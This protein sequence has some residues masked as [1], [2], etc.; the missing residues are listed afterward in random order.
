MQI[1]DWIIVSLMLA[2]VAGIA[3]YTRRFVKGVADFLAAG[4]VAGRYVVCVA[5]GEAGLGLISIVTVWEM[6]Y[7]SGFAVGWWNS[8][9]VPIYLLLTL[10]GF[11]IY[12]FRETRSMTLGQL[13]EI[14]YSK[15]FRIFAGIPSAISGIVNYGL[16][17][18]V[19]ARFLVYFCGLPPQL[20]A[21]GMQVPT[22]A[23]LMAVILA[24]GAALQFWVVNSL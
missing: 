16:F 6:Y 3:I 24:I 22:F 18:A 21:F 9:G 12:R 14:R 19:R 13:L 1:L 11:C 20:S 15:R 23:V 7:K 10:T 4:R 8:I 17:P 2:I 5:S